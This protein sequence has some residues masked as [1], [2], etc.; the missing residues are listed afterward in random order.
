MSKIVLNKGREKSVLAGNK[1]IFSGAVKESDANDG[2]VAD[3]V[4]SS[5]VFLG[6]AYYNSKTQIAARVLCLGEK[7]TD[8]VLLRNIQSAIL[9]RKISR[10]ENDTDAYRLIFSEA[11][12]IPGFI[13]DIF[14]SHL[15]IQSLTL[16]A[17]LLK[18]KILSMLIDELKPLSV[19]EKS[20]HAGR[21]LEGVQ[22]NNGQ[23]YGETPDEVI[24][25]EHGVKY[26]ID[27][28]TGQKTGFFIDQR[29]NRKLIKN[30]A[31]GRSVLN[32]FS[33]TGGFSFAAIAGGAAKATS[34]DISADALDIAEKTAALNGFE[35]KH[36]T[37]KADIFDLIRS[38]D[39]N[40][41]IIIIDPPAFV[42][43]KGAIDKGCRGYKDVNMNVF[44]HCA[45]NRIVLTCSCSRFVDMDLFQ[46][47]IFGAALDAKRNAY[48]IGKYSHPADH[49][50]NIY[51]PETEY[52]KAILLIV[53]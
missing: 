26:P 35:E 9:R 21:K 12:N 5:G 44:K 48:I 32:L 1:W 50:V 52:L 29:E 42:K 27:I 7:F 4:T 16:G 24:I 31:S 8:A 30:I 51:H 41:D 36:G 11:D 25:T 13:A 39:F 53:E 28:K 37:I 2:E 49:P 38:R 6:S 17:D 14:A 20:D 40:E 10:I 18:D 19:Y 34:V 43:S 46:K 15:S 22:S 33:Y 45:P 47:I 23:L 3:I